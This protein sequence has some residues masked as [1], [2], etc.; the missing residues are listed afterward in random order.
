MAL[1]KFSTSAVLLCNGEPPAGKLLRRLV[2]DADVFVC[3]DGGANAAHAYGLAP[4]VI[5]GDLDS[6]KPKTLKAFSN[7]M[8][9]RVARQDNTDMEKALDFCL[10]QG[11]KR[12]TVTGMTGGR[13]DMTLGNLIVLWKYIE[14]IDIMLAGTGWVGFPVMGTAQFRAP[15]GSTVSIIPFGALR[16]V[17]LQGLRYPLRNAT[18]KAGDIA[19]S[20]TSVR[21][22]FSVRFGSGKG[23]VIILSEKAWRL[24]S[25]LRGR[26]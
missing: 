25:P 9:I 21:A 24:R 4:D 7:A 26:R 16:G 22:Q 12:V 10:H 11:F 17:T 15:R 6:I 18:I 13:M 5:V 19:V 3:A 8:A 1:H 23:L 20:N 14:R 2:R